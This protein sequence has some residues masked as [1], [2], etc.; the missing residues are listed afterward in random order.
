MATSWEY[1]YAQ[2]MKGM[3]SSI[4][5]EI[6]KIT[7]QPDV[8]S[9]AGGMPAPEL[10]PLK[11]IEQACVKVLRKHGSSALQYS[12]SEGYVPLREFIVQKMARY[13]IMATVDNVLI[14]T[15]SQQGLD[16]V[17]RVLVDPGDVII[18]EAPTFVGALQSFT[19]Y[20]ASYAS[21]PLDDEGMMVDVLQQKIVETHPKFMYVLPNFQNPAGVTLSK[22]RRE[23]LVTLAHQYGVPILEDDPY[24]ELRFEGE[25][26]EPLV[27]L[28][29]RQNGQQSGYFEGD[30][31]YMS[32][33]SKTLAPGLRLGWVVAPVEVIKK[34][35]QAKQGADLHTS[36][37]DQMMAYEVVSD[38]FLDEHV[39]EIKETYRQ[40]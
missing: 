9:F 15:G 21:V 13:N 34:L 2:R 6:L 3:K 14:T 10:F 28:S 33:F 11:E 7:S 24:G 1:R 30:V 20:Q 35:V 40:R 5:R 39:K 22:N 18:V 19:A 17:A 32:T 37:F 27:V 23:R 38:G 4:V 31:I 29:A 16:L 8:I 25:H 26:L 12:I 36:T